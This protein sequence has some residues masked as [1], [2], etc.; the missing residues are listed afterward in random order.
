MGENLPNE[1]LPIMLRQSMVYV[2][3]RV[4]LLQVLFAS[5][6][7]FLVALVHALALPPEIKNV[8]FPLASIVSIP[9]IL[10][11]LYETVRILFDWLGV[12]YIIKPA[13]IVF[14]E[15]IINRKEKI[16]TLKHIESI[17]CNQNLLERFFHYGTIR[18]YNPFLGQYIHIDAINHPE[19]Y[20]KTIEQALPELKREQ[21]GTNDILE[22]PAGVLFAH[23]ERRFV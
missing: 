8:I 15:G 5:V 21:T 18:L 10:Y 11:Q 12:S 16:Y 13:E 3:I 23:M 20:V 14:K 9:I 2:A 22:E 19:K 6:Y 4:I 1:E 7:F 17:T